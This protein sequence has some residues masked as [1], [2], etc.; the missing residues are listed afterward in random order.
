MWDEKVPWC[1]ISCFSTAKCW[2]QIWCS[3]YYQYYYIWHSV[4]VYVNRRGYSNKSERSVPFLQRS[5]EYHYL[6][7]LLFCSHLSD[8][9]WPVSQS[10]PSAYF[11]A[12]TNP[13]IHRSVVTEDG[14]VTGIWCDILFSCFTHD[15][16][17]H[18][19]FTCCILTQSVTQ[20]MSRSM[21]FADRMNPRGI[22]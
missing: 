8:I 1:G 5:I 14:L 6:S 15:G 10:L 11:S 9:F 16:I 20:R 22:F 21:S 7:T 18:H 4:L 12:G 13:M 19:D 3:Q 17:N 2:L